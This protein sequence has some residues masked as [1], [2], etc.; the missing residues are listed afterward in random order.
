MESYVILD[1]TKL[2]RISHRGIIRGE[3][4]EPYTTPE[5][6]RLTRISRD[7]TMKKSYLIKEAIRAFIKRLKYINSLT[8]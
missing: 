1:R 5:I 3:Y 2:T 7:K 6:M 4:M 8:N